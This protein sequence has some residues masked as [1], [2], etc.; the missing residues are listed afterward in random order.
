[1]S[2]IVKIELPLIEQY[3]AI[4]WCFDNLKNTS[5]R[6][7]KHGRAVAYNRGLYSRSSYEWRKWL[8]SKKMAMLEEN[9]KF[10]FETGATYK[11]ENSSDAMMFK[12]R[13]GG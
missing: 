4:M 10:T 9:G 13:W 7:M 5:W 11:F 3:R 2:I 1:M 8:T 12:L 6:T